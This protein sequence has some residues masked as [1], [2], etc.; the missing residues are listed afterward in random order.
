MATAALRRVSK[1]LWAGLVAAGL[2]GCAG[3]PAQAPLPA[4]LTA[5]GT[6]IS[7]LTAPEAPQAL[8]W[9][10]DASLLA[11]A[12]SSGTQVMIWNT[13][14]G[15]MQW[16]ANRAAVTGAAAT[17]IAFTRDG[18]SVATPFVGVATDAPEVALTL[19]SVLNGK[20]MRTVMGKEPRGAVN[21]A[22]AFAL[23]G[24]VAAVV[25]GGTRI[26]LFETQRWRL[27]RT[28]GPGVDKAGRELTYSAIALDRRR[29]R[30]AV[31]AGPMVQIWSL[32]DGQLVTEY[33]AYAS[34]AVSGLAFSPADGSL[35][36]GGTL[37]DGG[38]PADYRWNPPPDKAS[39][40]KPQA[41]AARQL[42]RRWAADSKSLM[43]TYAMGAGAPQDI[44][45]SPDGQRVAVTAG[46]TDRTEKGFVMVWDLA[47][48][49][50]T[51]GVVHDDPAPAALAFSPDSSRLAYSVG[52]EVVLLDL[53][54]LPP[55]PP[56][57]PAPVEVPAAP[58]PASSPASSSPSAPPSSP[59]P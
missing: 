48:G 35:L 26:G 3:Q 45:V 7:R 29:D 25:L 22:H 1:V 31:A 14:S 30:L 43:Q 38:S 21:Q 54:R 20:V 40:P 12:G 16:K 49:A 17:D 47:S 27:L 10:P 53:T 50:L 36:T 32:T 5:P 33:P 2:A 58:A 59:A 28:I 6:E 15:R 44:A 55:P 46:K 41:V 57:E 34:G 18:L 8:A 11:A 9:S 52:K 42:V 19:L 37:P 56:P 24:D 23:D 4:V 13:A 39:P 51:G